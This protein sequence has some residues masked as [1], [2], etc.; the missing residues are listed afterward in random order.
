[1]HI[2]I[3]TQYFWPENFKINDLAIALKEKGH[4]VTVLTGLP[5]YPEGRIY[6]GYG[7]FRSRR[8]TYQGIKIIRV[9]ML[10]RFH[11][12]GFQLFLN[13]LTFA[14]SA[15]WHGLIRLRGNF[16]KIFVFEISPVTVGLPA[17]AIRR[18]FR[19]PIFFWVLDLWPESVFAAS[20]IRSGFLNRTLKGLVQYIYKR[21]ELILVSSRAFE[22]SVKSKGIPS[23]RIKY[24]PNWAEDL[25]LQSS[26]EVNASLPELPEGFRIIFAGNIGESQ[27]FETILSAA[28][29]IKQ[30][31]HIQWIIV[32][33]GRKREWLVSRIRDMEL[34]QTMHWMGKFPMADMPW[35]FSQAD[36]M[37]LP[38]KEDPIFSLTVPAKLQ[39]YLASKKPIIGLISGEGGRIIH[40][41]GAGYA[42]PS[43][44]A[45]GLA[46]NILKISGMSAEERKS[47]A[48]RGYAYYQKHFNK[49]LLMD[50]L[51]SM[52]ED[53]HYTRQRVGH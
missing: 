4:E 1:M 37:L 36:A 51:I 14:I 7:L 11:G 16:D 27:D 30:H 21:C 40:E 44:D 53:T 19:I 41:A 33:E 39:T 46:D 3:I 20:N 47:M 50:T 23:R 24:F 18:K 52:F 32:G 29:R 48:L 22:E 9:P 43:G 49:N 5:N 34:E 28:E 26:I 2:L 35:F 17:A 12:K 6:S 8:E 45:S 38:L 13:Y 15:T 25:F 10:P 42:S 31:K